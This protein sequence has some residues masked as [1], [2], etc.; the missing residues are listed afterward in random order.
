[1]DQ[2]ELF[3]IRQMLELGMKL[4]GHRTVPDQGHRTV[5]PTGALIPL[6]AHG[7]SLPAE[8]SRSETGRVV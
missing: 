4:L 6:P 3:L 5:K 8:I 1:M 2:P 7:T